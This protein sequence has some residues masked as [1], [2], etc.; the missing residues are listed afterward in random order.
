MTAAVQKEQDTFTDPDTDPTVVRHLSGDGRTLVGV[1]AERV[2]AWDVRSHRRIASWPGL[3]AELAHA[4]VLSPDLRTLTLV[5]DDGNVGFWD[6]RAGHRERQRM[7]TDADADDGAEIGP[8]GRT[9]VLYRTAGRQ[10][11][12][13]LRS[14]RTRRVLLERRM[15]HVVPALEA[16]EAFDV[17][18]WASRRLFQQRLMRRYPFPDV[19]L[20]ANDRLMALCLPGARLQIWDVSRRRQVPAAWAPE[21]TT[22]N[23]A[24]EGFQFTP[25]GR[26]LVLRDTT[27]VRTW[28][29]DSGRELTKIAHE[30]LEDLEFSPDGTYLAA[31][32]A[33]EVLLWRTDEP[34]APVFRSPLSDEAVSDLRWDTEGEEGSIRYFA[35]RSQTVVR[36]LSLDGVVEPRWRSRAAV[37]AAFGPEGRI[38]AVAHQDARTGRAKVRLH[39]GRNGK[40][41]TA[42]PAVPCPTVR[43]GPP[44]PAPCPVHLA[45]RPDGRVLAYGV[46]HPST[47]L[48]SEKLNLWDVSDRRLSRS[49]TVAR[50]DFERPGGR[51]RTVNGIAFH[52]D[53]TALVTSRIPAD[54]RLEYW[55]LRRGDLT[56]EISG[57]GGETLAVKPG[58]RILA[59]NHGQFLDLRTRRVARRVLTPGVTTTIAFSPDG[60]YLAAGDE[61]G[62]VTVWDG[63]ADKPLG[64][65]P[66]PPV[67]DG[68]PRYVTA[69]AFSPDGHT[70]AAAGENGT[71]RLWDTDSARPLGSALPTSGTALLALAFS[72][73]SRT[74]HAAGTHVLLQTFDIT[75]AHATARA[76]ER[77]GAGLTEDEWRT[78]VR[79]VPYRKTC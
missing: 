37:A 44:D 34:T 67:H 47:S 21:A 32:D 27:S 76:C 79:D 29:I 9:F 60:R 64:I 54:E 26:R 15:E 51:A 17:P 66:A 77:A 52:P 63:A 12:V 50:A 75:T 78:H 65:L 33:D 43:E 25:D 5:D 13:Q 42:L 22:A 20:S 46:S 56:R 69:L 68:T 6:V 72:P 19:Q 16:G 45:F 23:C 71:L 8:S 3:G 28:E 53:G 10:A 58:G 48:P 49:L 30:G 41:V 31:T 74:L 4:G 57:V 55:S 24:E 40:H 7:P 1:G 70:L 36:S 61:S 2:V 35:G 73:D 59:T 11:V 38:L 39:D 62:Q 14:M 18:D